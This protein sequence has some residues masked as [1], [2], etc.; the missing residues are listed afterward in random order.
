MTQYKNCKTDIIGRIVVIVPRF[1]QWTGTRA[2]HE[3]DF[4]I[5]TGGQ[6]PPKEVTKSLGL[7]AIIDTQHLRVFDRLKHKAE[8]VLEGCGVKYLSGWAV[9]EDKADQVFKSLD[10][11]VEQYSMEKADFLSRYD[12]LV[13]EWADQNPSFAKEIMEGKLDVNAVSERI[14]AGYESFRLQPVSAEKAVALA[15]SIGGLASELIA[16]VTRSARIFF[17]ESFLGKT[18]ASRKT[19]NAVLKIRQKLQGLAF[20][21]SSI[22]PVIAFIDKVVN[23][24]PSEGYF[25]GEPFWK[26]AALVKTLGDATLLEEIMTDPAYAQASFPGEESTGSRDE[27]SPESVAPKADATPH[28]PFEDSNES[29]KPTQQSSTSE[30]L[31]LQGFAKGLKAEQDLFREIDELFE[32]PVGEGKLSSGNRTTTP[33]EGELEAKWNE[34]SSISHA[35]VSHEHSADEVEPAAYVTVPTV[36]VGEGL[37]F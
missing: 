32:M 19:V 3:G 14:S 35:P 8:A 1:T 18:R 11:L 29:L 28:L 22:L 31:D 25:S 20:L 34:K 37:Y 7:K 13:K 17:K 10:A 26:L 36:D 30:S 6:L 12:S 16:S 4:A 2:M 27:T 15:K 24:M 33:L 21:S 5:G 9:P 23:E